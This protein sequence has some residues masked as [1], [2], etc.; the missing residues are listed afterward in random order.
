[1]RLPLS[2]LTLPVQL[3]S[4]KKLHCRCSRGAWLLA[5]LSLQVSG[6]LDPTVTL[7]QT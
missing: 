4:T 5:A 2:L 7:V 1:M 6:E 3:T